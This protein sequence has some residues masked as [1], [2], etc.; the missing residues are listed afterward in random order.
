MKHV[1]LAAILL[2]A[3]VLARADEPKK[4][5]KVFI[6][7]G[8]S[9]MEGKAK[10]ALFDYQAAQPVTRDLL[11]HLRKGDKWVERDAVWI[12]FLDRKGK[13]TVGYGSP[14]CVGP[15][16]EFGSVV[17]DH[18]DEP[19]LLIK[20]A[21]GGRSLYRDFRPPTAGLPPADVLDKM[22]AE[23]RKKKPDATLDDVKQPFGASYRA[24]IDEVNGTL[25]DL[26][27]LFPAYA[28]QG[29]ELAGFVWFQGWNDMINATYT[30]EYADNLRHFILDVRKDLKAPKLPFV[31]GQMGVDGANPEAGVKKFKAAQAAI[32]DFPEFKGNVALVPTDVYWDTEAEA[33]FK[34]GWREHLDEWNKVGSDYPYHY[35][36][37]AKTMLGIG[38]AFADAVLDLREDWKHETRVIEGWPVRI[39]LRLLDGPDAELGVRALRVLASKLSDIKALLPA[40]RLAKLQK[41]TIV[42]DRAHPRLKSMQYHPSVAWLKEHGH[43]PALA[44]CVHLPQAAEL[45]GRFLVNQQPMAILHELAHAYHDQFLGFDEPR[46]KAAWTR[47]KESGKYEKVL[48]VSGREIKHYALTNQMEFFAEMTESFFGTNDF[49]PFVRGELKKELPDVDRLLEEIWLKE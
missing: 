49:Y 32:M 15:E 14:G 16:L 31:V 5:V 48:H 9:N 10:V 18:Y 38:R 13:L 30:A 2:C 1:L 24:M 11:K 20:T 45:T 44:R 6:L 42:L 8:Q 46:I 28:G 40:D 37:S 36:G 35:L 7:A 25:K 21:W 12:K 23:Q 39:D 3:P 43:D 27:T 17:G 29:Y 4:P 22:L 41:V 47:F 19:V 34:K 26:K 33:V